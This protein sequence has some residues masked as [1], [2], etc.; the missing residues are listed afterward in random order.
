MNGVAEV[1]SCSSSEIERAVA[2]LRRG[3]LVAF[4]TETVYGLGADASNPDAVRK[5]FA[6]KGRPSDHPLIVHLA[7]RSRLDEWAASVPD[8]AWSLAR[9]FWPGPL[10]LI[11]RRQSCVPDAVTGGLD[12]V[13]I[14]VPNHPIALELLRAFGGG[15]A[16]PSANRFGR[17]SPTCAAHVREEL[18]DRVDMI[19]DGGPCSVGLESTIVDASGDAPA[20]LRPGAVTAEAIAEVLGFAPSL[21]RSGSPRAPGRLASHYAPEARVDLV[22]HGQIVA[23]VSDACRAH[24][25]IAVLATSPP[26]GLDRETFVFI[27]LPDEIEA[28]ARELYLALR[29]VDRAGCDL[30][31]VEL[32]DETGL[33]AAVADR[34]RKAAGRG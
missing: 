27:R 30:A 1:S 20:I 26:A 25:R 31:F 7:D 12:T 14:R 29:A 33:G 23:R 19:L 15:V 24:L 22:E 21:P 2:L 11:L 18:G 32:P 4:P 17:V 16:A 5:I 9:R 13:G 28:Q 3:E 6:A 34:L 8:F 10:T